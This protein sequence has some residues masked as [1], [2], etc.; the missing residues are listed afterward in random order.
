MFSRFLEGFVDG[1]KNCACFSNLKKINIPLSYLITPKVLS[2]RTTRNYNNIPLFNVKHEYFRNYFFLPTV[3]KWKK[4]EIFEIRNRLVLLKNKYL[5]LW[6]QIL[7][8]RTFNVHKLLTRLRVGLRHL[9]EQKFRHDFQDSLDPFYNC[10]WHIET[11][12][13]FFLHC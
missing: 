11:T 5:N 9:R 6:D 8:V 10:G 3:I 12:I 1:T 4:L 13:H 7:I 2:T